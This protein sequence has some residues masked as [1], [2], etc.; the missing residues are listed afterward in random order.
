MTDI[1]KAKRR[2]FLNYPISLALVSLFLMLITNISLVKESVNSSLYFCVST[3]VPSLFVFAV[4]G[5]ILALSSALSYIPLLRKAVSF[6][7]GVSEIGAGSVLI[8]LFSGY[9][10]GAF[11]A[12]ALYESDFIDR[13]E[14]V[15][16][17]KIS[18]NA[19]IAFIF[20]TVCEKTNFRFAL[21]LFISQTAASIAISV[22]ERINNR[23]KRKMACKSFPF[24]AN[25]SLQAV[26]DSIVKSALAM[27]SLCA[28]TAFFSA[29]TSLATHYLH[30]FVP[31]NAALI[32]GIIG[33]F[34]EVGGGVS[35][36]LSQDTYISHLLV[37]SAIGFGGIS[38]HMQTAALSNGG[39][40]FIKIAISRLFHS[41]I[42][43]AVFSMLGAFW[44]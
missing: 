42:T 8:G 13:E 20:G 27:L 14:A 18:N 17:T 44:Q 5:R 41:L 16:I 39:L 32:G 21:S 23:K 12:F 36:L 11:S 7:F 19:G 4:M 34:F 29:L 38:V 9:P 31:H 1:C 33:A 40:P 30:R 25:V 28:F 10:M 6:I 2:R 24:S 35:R 43:T 26:T 15:L 37:A 3:V 22:F